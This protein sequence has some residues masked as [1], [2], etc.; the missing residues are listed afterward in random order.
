MADSK[1]LRR[2]LEQLFESQPDDQRL[3]DHLEGVARDEHFPGL[4]WFW[5]PVLYKRNRAMFRGLILNHFSDWERSRRSWTR[6]KWSDHATSLEAWLAAARTN[7]DTQM[8]RRLL[9]WK[10]AAKN[11]GVDPKAWREALLQDYRAAESAAAR[12]IVL[13]EYDDWF[14][15]DESTALE[16]YERDRACSAFLLKHLPHTFWG[17]E[18]RKLWERLSQAALATGDEKLHFE[19]YR[20][21]V[22]LKRWRSDVAALARDIKD[23]E[24]LNEE[25]RR[26]HPAGYGMNLSD[27]FIEMLEARGRDVMPY[28]R[29]HL[30]DAVGGWF[31]D[32]AKPIA[33]LAERRGWWDLW[34]AAIRA[35]RNEKLFNATVAELLYDEL[36]ADST[37][38]NRLSALAGVSR[39]WNWPGLGFVQ[40]HA[41]KDEIAAELFHRFPDLVRGPYKP[42]VT[43]T[44]W[45]GYPELLKAAQQAGDE[46]LVDLLASRYATQV[47]YDY[48]YARKERDRMMETAD[49]LGDYFAA[50]RDK[51]RAEFARRAANVLTRV[52][53]YVLYNYDQ[54]LRTNKLARLLFVRSFEAYLSVPAAVR[55]LVEGS[56]VHVQMLGYRVLAQDDERAR[57]LAVETLDILIGTLLRP[58]HRKT[59]LAAFGALANAARGDQEAAKFILRRAREALRLPDK[60]Y[61]KENLIGLIGQVLHARPELRGAGE[62]P[63]I[64]GLEEAVA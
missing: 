11:W 16:L 6:V 56:E 48:G 4:T 21:Q 2:T 55:D 20:R 44:W 33:K 63:V 10:H 15:L 49:S 32:S 58:L 37:R 31:G 30:K 39:E 19:L 51:D 50:I 54:L 29:A 41:L 12:A 57:R 60:R 62:Q 38:V 9:R 27:A 34:A 28:V 52:P 47:R 3:R 59:R 42:H 1:R 17:N 40:L 13:D 25:L 22:P 14:E 5:G 46:D 45:Q 61:P 7:R 35:S 8:V 36:I 18:K 26:R 23:P 24:Q 64:Y 43:P 53:A